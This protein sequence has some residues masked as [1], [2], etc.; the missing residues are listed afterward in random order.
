LRTSPQLEGHGSIAPSCSP[1]K[2]RCA[3]ANSLAF[4]GQTSTWRGAHGGF[5]GN[6]GRRRGSRDEREE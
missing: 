4:D 5:V 3:E 6:G 2:Q 1:S